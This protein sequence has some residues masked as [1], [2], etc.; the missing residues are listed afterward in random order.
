MN[1]I[2]PDFID[3][4]MGAV[5]S[6]MDQQVALYM[7]K[8]MGWMCVGLL[9]TFA[10]M[11]LCLTSQTLM[12]TLVRSQLMYGVFI[13]QFIVVIA[14]TAGMRKFSPAVATV[15]FMVYSALTGVTFVSLFTLFTMSSLITV[16]AMTAGIFILMAVYGF[17]TKR[18]L[19]RIG[20]LALFA[21]LGIIVAGIFNLFI[22]NSMLDFIICAVGIVIFIV[23]IAYDTQ[24]IKGFYMGA[25]ASGEDDLSPNVQKLA[26]YGALTL[27]LDFINLFLKLL[28]IFGKRRS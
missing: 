8:V 5:D 6:S 22:L 4:E 10:T 11:M 12:Y 25:L 3:R 16:F 20:S 18:D 1:K 26:I 19:T 9:T 24:K 15:M 7:A 23:L 14:M 27:Y 13:A 28:R 17:V 2:Q 21:L